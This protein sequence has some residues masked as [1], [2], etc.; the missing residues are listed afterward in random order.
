MTRWKI[1][2]HCAQPLPFGFYWSLAFVLCIAGIGVST[3]LAISHY[4]VHTDPVY[5]S[6]CAIS[7]SINC[8]TVSQSPYSVWLG[9]PLAVWGLVAYGFL[10]LLVLFSALPLAQHRRVW[11]ILFATALF[12]SFLSIGF[13]FVSA[14][15]IG[16]WCILCI[17]TY[18]I[19][20]LL[21]FLIWIVRKRFRTE[22]FVVA[23]CQDLRF[24][25]KH[26][27]LTGPVFGVFGIGLA[28][29]TL[30]FPAYWDIQYFV[31]S[32]SV[33]SGLTQEGFPW[34]GSESPEIEIVEFTDYQCFQCRKMHFYMLQI[35]AH[36][37]GKV[38]VIHRHFPMDHAYNPI[39]V[40]PHHVGSGQMAILAIHAAFREKFSK[41]N[42]WLFSKAGQESGSISLAEAA[43]AT[44]IDAGELAA[45]LQYDRYRLLLKRDIHEGIRLGVVG[46]PSYLINGRIYEGS[47]PAEILKPLLSAAGK[48]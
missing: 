34:S 46:T 7:K 48:G 32:E 28:L 47:L 11:T 12:C 27:K 18:G 44:G 13:A 26:I 29:T 2:K 41:M 23:F 3:C 21:T 9:L 36:Y 25:R 38:R 42:D 35:L 20:L 15:F 19:N 33:R 22:T 10:M 37:P 4:R 5:E 14:F 45:A 24:L 16:S 40:E 31:E 8:D 6:F 30:W 43:T 1:T 17:A 39:V